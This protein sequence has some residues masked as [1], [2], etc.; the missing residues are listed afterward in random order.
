MRASF[1][2]IHIVGR[3]TLSQAILVMINYDKNVTHTYVLTHTH[4]RKTYFKAE[5]QLN[6][7]T[8][9]DLTSI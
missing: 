9:H 8:F 7:G 6:E 1:Y 3:V 2:A 5:L 4:K